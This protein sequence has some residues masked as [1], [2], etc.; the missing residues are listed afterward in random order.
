[1]GVD[2]TTEQ[3]IERLRVF[4]QL[5]ARE[6]E[7]LRRRLTA[8]ARKIASHEGLDPQ[9]VIEHM[10][11]GV[12][13]DVNGE[14]SPDSPLTSKSERWSGDDEHGQPK[15]DTTQTGHGP[16]EQ[17]DLLKQEALFKLDEADQIC[18]E[19][20][21]ELQA[22]EGWTEDSTEIDVVEV[23]YV[24]RTVKK[25]KYRCTCSSCQHIE[26]ALGADTPK[27]VK[28][29]RY[30][31]DFAIQVILDKYA[32]HLPL[33]RQSRRMK[34]LGLTVSSQT[35]WDY[36]WACAQW[37]VPTYDAQRL[38]VLGEDVVG[39]DETRWRLMGTTKDAKPQIIAL[40][41]AAGVW[42][43]FEHDKTAETI[44][45]LLGD[46]DGVLVADGLSIYTAVRDRRELAY[47]NLETEVKPFV[48]VQCWV[49]GRRYFIK[50]S[51][52]DPHVEEMLL[53]IGRLYRLKRA[54][55]PELHDVW[56]EWTDAVLDGMQA[57]MTKQRPRP[58]SQL[59]RAIAYTQKRWKALTLFRDNP[60]IWL[61]NNGTERALRLAIQGRKNHYGSR[62]ERGM[63]ASGVMYSLIETCSRLD[64][65][66]R[67]YFREALSRAIEN[68]G[69]VYTPTM[70]LAD[71]NA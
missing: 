14:S 64:I 42:Y 68:P 15:P 32:S 19:C 22:I 21:G 51:R 43:G 56:L 59:E 6:L 16:T 71:L 69:T 41:S 17:P 45:R 10:L 48:L 9:A 54:Y 40:T 11:A 61:D 7:N 13:T 70:Y 23:Q 24:V 26:T 30:T 3:D 8:S 65:D 37:L 47:Q 57:W 63:L 1:M 55:T 35:L 53:L 27:P 36:T 46:F 66:T 50:A 49:H 60:A 20:G 58:G 38:D 39:A 25:Q 31:L 29:G 2:I 44:D 18:P 67:A 5:Q 34:E 28:G 4:S 52:G 12:A 62:S 33:D